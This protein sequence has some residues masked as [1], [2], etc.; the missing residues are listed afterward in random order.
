MTFMPAVIDPAIRSVLAAVPLERK[1]FRSVERVVWFHVWLVVSVWLAAPADSA[2]ARQDSPDRTSAPNATAAYLQAAKLQNEGRYDLAAP[3]WLELLQRFPHGTLV[4][5][6]LFYRGEALYQLGRKDEA[7][8]VY[9]Q[10]I[11]DCENSQLMADALYA[12][13]VAHQEL[14]HHG[15]AAQALEDFLKRFPRHKLCLEVQLR[16]AEATL[17][18]GDP[19]KAERMFDGLTRI[20]GF[21]LASTALFRQAHCG[22]PHGL[23]CCRRPVCPAGA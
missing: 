22:V 23:C 10:M 15:Q 5:R 2:L 3:Q 8:Q 19:Q 21:P 14:G 18:Q 1:R 9:A 16:Q 12:L 20:E 11:R 6:A 4:D 13:A 17:Q 7:I